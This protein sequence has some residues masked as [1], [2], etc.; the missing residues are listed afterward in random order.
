MAVT[1]PMWEALC[2]TIEREEL[3]DDERFA[4]PAD[5]R[6]NRDALREEISAWTRQRTKQE[7]MRELN[8][9]GVPASAVFDTR[10]IFTDPHLQQRGFIQTVQHETLGP[11]PLLGWPARLSAS[12]VP[13]QAA[14]LLGRHTSEVLTEDL[15]LSPGDIQRMEAEGIIE[16]HHRDE[17]A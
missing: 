1:V 4:T 12:D 8:E 3:I 6:E 13:I 15:D 17:N 14:P 11:I 2:R 9:A 16:V 5:R 7:A 10:D